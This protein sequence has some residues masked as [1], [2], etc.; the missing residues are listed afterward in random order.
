MKTYYLWSNEMPAQANTDLK[1]TSSAYFFNLLRRPE[2]VKNNVI[3]S[4]ITE[5]SSNA[6]SKADAPDA[7]ETYV[8]GLG[9]NA[10]FIEIPVDNISHYAVQVMY[11]VPGSP[12]HNAGL[13]RGDLIKKY[14]GSTVSNSSDVSRIM[15]QTSVSLT[16]CDVYGEETETVSITSATYANTPI[17]ASLVLQ[18]EDK[19]IG[20]L[21]YNEFSYGSNYVFLNE[22]KN[23]FRF[24]KQNEVNELVLDLRYNP[25]GYVSAATTLASMI[26]GRSAV[27]NKE[28]FLIQEY[29][30]IY[31]EQLKSKNSEYNLTRFSLTNDELDECN[32]DLTSIHIIALTNTA[33]ASEL[34]IHCLKPYMDVYHYGDITYGKNLGSVQISDNSGTVEWILQPIVSRVHDCNNISGYENGITPDKTIKENYALIYP[35]GDHREVILN[36]VLQNIITAKSVRYTIPTDEVNFEINVIEDLP[37]IDKG[38][39]N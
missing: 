33:S 31:S 9:F 22:L 19:N 2:Q 13:K 5:S 3:F 4:S 21:M 16:L 32:L 1:S 12:A 10:R 14:N 26:V 11:I 36:T 23:A 24:F 39:I 17:L 18:A 7:S 27:A 6:K 34:I 28:V 25:G 8:S 20:Y 15:S 38:V 30:D 35:F 29:N 37:F